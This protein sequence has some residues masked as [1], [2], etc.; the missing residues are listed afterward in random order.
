[1]VL[2]QS[3]GI[4]TLNQDNAVAASIGPIPKAVAP[5]KNSKKEIVKQEIWI[6]GGCGC[7]PNMSGGHPSAKHSSKL[8]KFER[9]VTH[10]SWQTGGWRALEQSSLSLHERAGETGVFKIPI[11]KQ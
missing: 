5:N 4:P 8:Y 10:G 2:N 7:G 3:S 9:E 11:G 6:A 1:M